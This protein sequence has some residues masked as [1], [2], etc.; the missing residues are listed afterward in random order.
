MRVLRRLRA[1]IELLTCRHG[2]P[3]IRLTDAESETALD[4]QLRIHSRTVHRQASARTS[5]RR[6]AASVKK[7]G[8]RARKFE[9]DDALLERI[10]CSMRPPNGSG[11]EKEET[12]A[13]TGTT[14]D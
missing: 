3:L 10:A 2:V 14:E 5:A 7:F 13:K 12:Q 9:I 4:S 6:A 1:W 8:A 11:N